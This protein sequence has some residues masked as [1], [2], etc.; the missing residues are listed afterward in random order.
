[1]G[2]LLSRVR[3]FGKNS[4]IRSGNAG[5]PGSSSVVNGH[6]CVAELLELRC[7]LAGGG[8][9]TRTD[10]ATTSIP[11]DTWA[12][13]GHAHVVAASTPPEERQ[14]FFRPAPVLDV[15]EILS[16][17]GFA[18]SASVA[19]ASAGG[20]SAATSS[21]IADLNSQVYAPKAEIAGIVSSNAMAT[22][23]FDPFSGAS[24]GGDALAQ[25]EVAGWYVYDDH[26]TSTPIDVF[27]GTLFF[28]TQGLTNSPGDNA[29]A[30]VRGELQISISV[31]DFSASVQFNYNH[32]DGVLLVSTAVY[33]GDLDYLNAENGHSSA[34]IPFS[35]NISENDPL[36]IHATLNASSGSGASVQGNEHADAVSVFSSIGTVFGYASEGP[37]PPSPNGQGDFDTDGDADFDDLDIWWRN[38]GNTSPRFFDGDA[39]LDGDVDNDDL[40][41]WVDCIPSDV[42]F[43]SDDSDFSDANYAFGE[44]SLREALSLASSGAF[45]G[46]NSIWIAPWIEEIALGGTQLAVTSDVTIVGFGANN[47]SI[48]AGGLSRVF[49]VSSGVDATISGLT[50]TGGSVTAS[51]PGG[52]VGG[53][54]LNQGDLELNSV[55]VVGNHTDYT[56]LSGTNGGGGIQSVGGDLRIIDSTIEGNRGRY[57]GGVSVAVNAG[58]VLE[59]SGSTISNNL[60]LSS[61]NDGGGGGVYVHGA[62]TASLH[63]TNATF[64]GN[65]SQNAA[66][67]YV[68]SATTNLTIVNATIADNHTK[69]AA[70]SY[71]S[72]GIAAGINNFLAGTVTLHNTILADNVASNPAW[73]NGMGTLAGA[74]SSHNLIDID[75]SGIG[76]SHSPTTTGN[77]VGSGS[78]LATLLA[79]LGD[80]GG[81]TKTHAL[82]VGSPALDAGKGSLSDTLD[83]RGYVREYDL[84]TANGIDGYRDIGAYEAGGGT[85]L[86]VRSDGDRNDSVALKAT[87]D[88]LRLREALALSAAL[89]GTETIS[90]DQSSW[91]DS[92]IQLLSTWGQLTINSGVEIAGPGVDWLTI[93]AAPSSRVFNIG[94][95]PGVTLSGMKITGGA[96]GGSGGGI[97]TNSPSVTL[98]RVQI[99]NNSGTYGGGVYV[100]AYGGLTLKN[101]TVWDNSATGNGGGIYAD[102]YSN[103]NVL[104][105]TLSANA[106]TSIGGGI[107]GASSATIR[108]VNATIAYNSAPFG[109]GGI[110][111]SGGGV[112][113]DNTI[114][115]NNSST[116]GG[117]D[118]SGTFSSSS[119]RNLIG[120]DATI[121]NGIDNGDANGNMVGANARLKA[122]ADY[123]GGILTHALYSDS[124]AIDAGDNAIATSFVLDEDQRGWDRI[125]DF[126]SDDPLDDKIDI[127]AVELAMEEIYS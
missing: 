102:S 55:V 59:I 114:V 34:F 99:D 79:P 64:S 75:Y 66:A 85:T 46:E 7:M 27:N 29:Y 123:G 118:I 25:A 11:E 103:V 127:G 62:T 9:F 17:A 47:I 92:D 106:S 57:G 82:K 23:I 116:F 36:I 117:P 22:G 124:D 89:A 20:A 30:E 40:E 18:L 51:S 120:I 39:D 44:L 91:G 73:H 95:V 65:R 70:G 4:W 32:A 80:Y 86:I 101:S 5:M 31:G 112:R 104:N 125:V 56:N 38:Q 107:Y 110:Y 1:M 68:G 108:V 84:T 10:W 21:L 98:D 119:T 2:R 76:I 33:G 67:I 19:R 87:V 45:P 81:K 93:S 24:A 100:A 122:L 113:L 74:S 83:Q 109:G 50:I 53:G 14:E 48:D 126:E 52:N 88:S 115:S 3:A 69:D 13:A 35:A 61:S 54:I 28:S 58:K 97:Y 111:K 96:A 49:S 8:V 37:V 60:A 71:I 77:K 105:S 41:I 94:G 6:R 90:F 26:D 42:I 43:V 15:S 63:I 78:R 12:M 121:G 16:D 72:G